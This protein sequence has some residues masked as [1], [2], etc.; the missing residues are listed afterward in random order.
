MS[1]DSY[2]AEYGME[3]PGQMTPEDV[4]ELCK[5]KPDMCFEKAKEFCREDEECLKEWEEY[6]DGAPR[7]GGAAQKLLMLWAIVPVLD[8]A[9]G[10]Y[11]Y[12]QTNQNTNWSNAYNAE[13]AWGAIN[14]AAWGAAKFAKVKAVA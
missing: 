10:Y 6:R 14:L 12:D 4:H 11:N 1:Y 9:A 8:L 7:K 13:F 5:Q 3:A 2:G